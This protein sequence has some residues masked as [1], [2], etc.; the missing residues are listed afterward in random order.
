MTIVFDIETV[1]DLDYTRKGEFLESLRAECTA[2]SNWKD[3]E[4]IAAEVERLFLARRQKLALSPRTGKVVAIACGLLGDDEVASWVSEDEQEVVGR[5]AD[6]L[7][8]AGHQTLAGFNIRDFDLPFV[9]VRSAV[10]G[11][12][13]PRWWP[14]GR[15]YRNVA[16]AR[17][18]LEQGTLAD[19]LHRFGLPHKIGHGADV[20]GMLPAERDAYVRNDVV[21]ERLL[22]RRLQRSLPALRDSEPLTPNT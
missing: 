19:W 12:R 15:D 21:V 2:P 9:S 10:C 5:F 3:P 14:H 18:V 20:A 1:E 22:L 6:Y 8:Q 4:K 16:D 17:D 13:L 7:L 11:V